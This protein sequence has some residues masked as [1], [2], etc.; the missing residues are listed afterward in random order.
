MS[1]IRHWFSVLLARGGGGVTFC[2]DDSTKRELLA[3]DFSSVSISCTLSATQ[4]G[5]ERRDEQAGWGEA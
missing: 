3:S 4:D 5:S 1:T 2:T